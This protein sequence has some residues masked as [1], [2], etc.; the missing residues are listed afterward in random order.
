ML[1]TTAIAF[2]VQ[3]VVYSKSVKT[4]EHKPYRFQLLTLPEDEVLANL[5]CPICCERLCVMRMK[6]QLIKKEF[7]YGQ[8]TR[9]PC[10]HMAHVPCV[11]KWRMKSKQ[12]PSCFP[13]KEEV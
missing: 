8:V 12:C 1:I 3:Y 5:K 6:H 13:L 10:D 9:F 7:P 4:E 2:T 11:H